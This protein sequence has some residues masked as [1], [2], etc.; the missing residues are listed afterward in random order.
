V[1]PVHPLV[2]NHNAT[3]MAN[4]ILNSMPLNLILL[5]L[6]LMHNGTHIHSYYLPIN[7]IIVV[8]NAN[9]KILANIVILAST[10]ILVDQ[11]DLGILTNLD[12]SVNINARKRRN[13]INVSVLIASAYNIFHVYL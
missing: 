2:L 5:N 4:Y 8:I 7:V 13:V 11:V 10:V 12:A 1:V 9:A 3:P 6:L